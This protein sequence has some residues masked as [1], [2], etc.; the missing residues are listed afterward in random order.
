MVEKNLLEFLM[1][2][3]FF[4]VAFPPA[5]KGK[6]HPACSPPTEVALKYKFS[7]LIF[8]WFFFFF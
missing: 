8:V 4:S 6:T 5:D 3:I 2:A 1:R 7:W